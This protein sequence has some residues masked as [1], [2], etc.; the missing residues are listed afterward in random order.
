MKTEKRKCRIC[1]EPADG[2]GVTCGKTRCTE[3]NA[4]LVNGSGLVAVGD[5]EKLLLN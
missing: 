5:F 4:K 2:Y 3:T 1:E